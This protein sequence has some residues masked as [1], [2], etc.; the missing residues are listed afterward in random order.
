[1]TTIDLF[2]GNPNADID[3]IVGILNN[4]Q[5]VEAI[6][7]DRSQDAPTRAIFTGTGDASNGSF[8]VQQDIEQTA[9]ASPSTIDPGDAFPVASVSE[10]R[11]TIYAATKVAQQAHVTLEDVQKYRRSAVET[12]IRQ[13]TNGY[14]DQSFGAAVAALSEVPGA[15]N[16]VN[17]VAFAELTK[18]NDFGGP[19]QRAKALIRNR[20]R[21]FA[22]NVIVAKDSALAELAANDDIAKLLSREDG[23]APV[24]TGSLG[25]AFG[26]DFVAIPDEL[27]VGTPF[28][29]DALVVDNTVLGGVADQ[30]A[31]RAGSTWLDQTRTPAETWSLWLAH[32]YVFY[33]A[34]P[35]AGCWIAGVAEGTED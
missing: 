27:T 35:L 2:N 5:A 33:V 15:G 19:V 32:N 13:M 16:T 22:A 7:H 20:R 6:L 1:M 9:S 8:I 3:A 25:R 23:Q 31:F 24:Y 4:T 30:V 10:T 29:T 17:G 26:L 12:G 28:E 14:V 11:P 34:N 18:G 21:G